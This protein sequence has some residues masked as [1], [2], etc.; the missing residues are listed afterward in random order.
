MPINAHPDYLAAEKKYNLDQTLEEKLKSLEKMISFAPK[1]KG[2]E[3]LRAQ[4][5]TRY[6]KLKE[7]IGKEKQRG[8][9]A[10]KGIKKEDM[11]AVIIGLTNTGKSSLISALTNVNT[12]I[13]EHNFTTKEPIIGMMN[14]SKTNI[15]LIEIPA[16]ES[17]YYDKGT[18]HTADTILILITSLE[19][20]KN[21]EEKL[22]KVN[23]KKI[24]IFNKID[25]L[26]IQERRKISATLA[27]KKYNFIL[28]ST[29]TKENLNELKNKIFQSFDKIRIY[30]KEPGKEKSKKPIIMKP[31]STIKDVAEKILKGFSEKVKETK[32]WGPS[33][34]FPGQKV[35][36]QH[37]LKNLDV[38]QFKTR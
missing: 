11:Q 28:V 33:S 20:I 9:S 6:K 18:V 35:G 15:Q 29:K 23:G 32:I 24:I 38:V 7:K 25:L 37:K 2:G 5:K 31:D 34:K 36:L 10:K 17:E 27:S 13:S 1:H 8:K 4:L 14:Y 12:K 16:F 30:T 21:I 26:N 19:Q 3:N 22:I